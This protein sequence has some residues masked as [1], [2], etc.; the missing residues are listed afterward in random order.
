VLGLRLLVDVRPE[1]CNEGA[2]DEGWANARQSDESLLS[3][4][5]CVR[6]L[7]AYRVG[8]PATKAEGFL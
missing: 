3:S 7:V 6:V 1:P 8:E 4:K 2:E 5:F